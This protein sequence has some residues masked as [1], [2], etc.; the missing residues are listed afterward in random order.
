MVRSELDRKDLDRDT[1]VSHVDRMQNASKRMQE[2]INDLLSYS[3]ISRDF[4][5]NEAIDL[6]EVVKT[7]L[8]DLEIPI[9][10]NS[11]SIQVAELPK[12]LIAD[13]IQMRQL[14]QNLISNAIKFRKA[15]IS[16]EVLIK[17]KRISS[18]LVPVPE[19]S[20]LMATSYWQIDVRD[21]GIGFDEQYAEK[22]FAV[23]QRLHGR[24][25]YSGTGIGLSICKKICENH[26]GF[27][28]AS[29]EPGEGSTFSIYLPITS[30]S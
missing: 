5:V 11:A 29:S 16:P 17:A 15:D 13:E 4:K 10:E 12:E 9:R 20:E 26:K 19:V 6:N 30:Q 18:E 22:I 1:V 27:I 23:F 3:R 14:F 24:S 8:N 28:I 2:L 7:V 25:S 21:N